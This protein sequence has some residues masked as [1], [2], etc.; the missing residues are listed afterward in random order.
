VIAVTTVSTPAA[1]SAKP[2]AAIAAAAPAASAPMHYVAGTAVEVQR[3]LGTAW[4]PGTVKRASNSSSSS[5]SSASSSSSSQCYDIDYADGGVEVDVPRHLLRM[6]PGRA[7]STAKA[8]AAQ[9]ALTYKVGDAVEVKQEGAGGAWVHG[10][11]TRVNADGAYSVS[12]KSGC[13]RADMLRVPLL[14]LHAILLG[15]GAVGKSRIFD[16][17]CGAGYTDSQIITVGVDRA[18]SCA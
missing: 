15:D 4:Y 7:A 14:I 9:L 13:V 2:A 17:W 1:V 10:N 16:R 3:Y 8:A 12:S 6:R 11:V 18:V 5:S